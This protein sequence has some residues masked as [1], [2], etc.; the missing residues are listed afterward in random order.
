MTPDPRL[1]PRRRADGAWTPVYEP[2]PFARFAGVLL[3]V[4]GV[5]F[6]WW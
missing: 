5:L 2:G 4:V 1:P 6:F 3:R